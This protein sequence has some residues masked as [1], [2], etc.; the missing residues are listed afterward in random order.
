MSTSPRSSQHVNRPAEATISRTRIFTNM[1]KKKN[2]NNNKSNQQKSQ[3][4]VTSAKTGTKSAKAPGAKAGAK[5]STAKATKSSKHAGAGK[6]RRAAKYRQDEAIFTAG[7]AAAAPGIMMLGMIVIIFLIE[8]VGRADT[9]AQVSI[10]Q[11]AFRVCDYI[12][13]AIGLVFLIYQGV[14]GNLRLGLTTLFGKQ[15]QAGSTLPSGTTYLDGVIELCFIAFMVCIIISTCI[16]GLNHDAAFG[17][18]VRYIG[19]FNTFAFFII[20]MKVSSYIEGDLFRHVVLVGFLLV[21]DLI[22]LTAFWN[23]YLTPIP[24]YQNKTGISA[25]FANSNHYGYFLGIAVVIGIGYF[26]YE[27]QKLAIIGVASAVLNLITLALNDTRGAVLAAG[28][29]VVIMTIL[30]AVFDRENKLVLKKMV[31]TLA[32]FV[33]AVLAAIAIL[34]EVRDSVLRL[35]SDL[36]AILTG[37]TNGYEGSSRIRVWRQVADYIGNRP[38]FGYGCEGVTMELYNTLGIGDAHSEPMTYALYY[39]TPAMILYLFGM[40][41]TAVK[42]FK[43]RLVLP[44][45]CRIAFLGACTY[46]LSS[47]IG[48]AMFYT[49]PFFFVFLGMSAISKTEETKK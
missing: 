14:H 32:F 8:L 17:L 21:A 29:C 37:N 11:G 33:L 5:D 20:Y 41:L 27:K 2:K 42:Y 6:A 10:Y 30:V 15:K 36:V 35:F 18:P 49:T 25:I 12:A 48:V 23:Q 47:L 31:G 19:I 4:K 3:A 34:P 16:N 7:C 43:S 45:T 39:G 28:I 38:A 40:I 26:V 24:A 9:T 1:S 46:F 13:I 22:A 44:V